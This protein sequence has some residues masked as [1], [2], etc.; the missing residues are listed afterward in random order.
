[1]ANLASISNPRELR[2]TP[3]AMFRAVVLVYCG[4]LTAIQ[5]SVAVAVT[6][7]S[8]WGI[9]YV[10]LAFTGIIFL[11][12][13]L[14]EL[15]SYEPSHSSTYGG[16]EYALAGFTVVITIAFTGFLLLLP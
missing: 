6:G 14:Q 10:F 3:P 7:V 1:M 2:D 15:R 8:G 13:G 9:G 16:R 5:G 4:T 11:A 12:Q